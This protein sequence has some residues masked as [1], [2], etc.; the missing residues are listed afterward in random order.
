MK[1][2]EYVIDDEELFGVT[3][4][5]LVDAPAI[6]VDFVAMS[7]Q[8]D[9]LNFAIQDE[10]KRIVAGPLMIPDIKIFRKGKEGQEDFY[11]TFSAETI[12]KAA[13]LYLKKNLQSNATIQHM[14]PVMGVTLVE[15]WTIEG[16]S[17]KSQMYG[18]NLPKGTWFGIMRVDNDSVWQ[19]VKAGEIKGFSVESFFIPTE[20]SDFEKHLDDLL[21]ELATAHNS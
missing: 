20:R 8:A 4:I 9:A 6:E 16:D 1:I 10:E 5:S 3:A 2:V 17:D 15:S 11:A 19:S 7:K 18:Y 13:R 12:I 14:M 21:A